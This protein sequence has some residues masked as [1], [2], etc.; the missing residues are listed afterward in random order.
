M[1]QKHA[2]D[3]ELLKG[4]LYFSSFRRKPEDSETV[5]FVLVDGDERFAY[6]PFHVDFGPIS[7][8]RTLRFCQTLESALST[9][10]EEGKVLC[11][12]SSQAYFSRS[13]GA[14]LCCAYMLLNE[15]KSVEQAYRPFMGIRPPLTSF[16]DVSGMNGVP[17]LDIVRGLGKALNLG[18]LSVD[19]FDIEQAEKYELVENGDIAWV[20]PGRFIAFAGPYNT[21]PGTVEA[22]P[23]PLTSEKGYILHSPYYYAK[24]FAEL[25]VS[26]VVRLNEKHYDADVF[27]ENGFQHHEIFFEDGSTP[28]DDIV[29]HFLKVCERAK[30]AVAV[31]CKAGLGRTGTLIACFLMKTYSF[32]AMEA[33]GFIRIM[34]PGSII[35]QQQLY[36]KRSEKPLQKLGQAKHTQSRQKGS[37]EWTQFWAKN[38][39]EHGGDRPA[40]PTFPEPVHYSP[41][42]VGANPYSAIMRIGTREKS[43]AKARRRPSRIGSDSSSQILSKSQSSVTMSIND[44]LKT[45]SMSPYKAKPKRR[46]LDP[47]RSRPVTSPV[48]SDDHA[49]LRAPPANRRKSLQ[50]NLSQSSHSKMEKKPDVATPRGT[51]TVES[52]ESGQDICVDGTIAI[53]D[54]TSGEPGQDGAKEPADASGKSATE[55][56]EEGR[57]GPEVLKL[58]SHSDLSSSS[59]SEQDSLHD[60]KTESGSESESEN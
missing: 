54:A 18:L 13:N 27:S 41:F 36:L 58:S 25:G 7:I 2:F 50:D 47:I 29:I 21:G 6:L 1:K 35:G 49:I 56:K 8:T 45:L 11:V 37:K 20:V 48:P 51:K 53:V 33:I 28:A 14:Y 40:S 52:D 10:K 60:E 59:D 44:S 30:G 42:K 39:V 4:K 57:G 12:A 15:K 32:T 31:H 5:S 22:P 43:P 16:C 19:G 9:A 17:L 24:V 34:R 46:L 55:M 3:V 26:D 38:K 23:P